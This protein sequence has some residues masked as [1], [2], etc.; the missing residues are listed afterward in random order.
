[1]ACN[2]DH[3]D[4]HAFVESEIFGTAA[5]LKARRTSAYTLTRVASVGDVLENREC[6]AVDFGRVDPFE[7]IKKLLGRGVVELAVQS[8]QLRPC[9][10]SRDRSREA[11]V[12]E[13][14]IACTY[15][16]W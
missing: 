7:E 1:M 10:V 6:T 11:D 12:D 15:R 14:V 3:I 9:V 16:D 2:L 4:E 5:D 8:F 13:E